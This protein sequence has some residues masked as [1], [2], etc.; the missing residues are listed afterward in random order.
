MKDLLD[1]DAGVDL[2]PLIDVVF[3]L[4]VFFIMTTTFSKPV[5]EIVLPT[6]KETQEL[7]KQEEIVI[8]IT[9]TGGIFYKDI[10]LSEGQFEAL[11]AD[12]PTT[13]L[14][15][16]VDKKAPFDSFIQVIDKAKAR[17]GGSFVISTESDS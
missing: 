16:H 8:A 15:L 2:T 5:V 3:M 7:E 10:S 9:E 6:A 11:L 17:E 14:N 1:D 12:H 13:R 4:L